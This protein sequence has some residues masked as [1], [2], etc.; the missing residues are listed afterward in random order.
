MVSWGALY[1]VHMS[2]HIISCVFICGL[3]PLKDY[4]VQASIGSGEWSV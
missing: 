2:R 4:K 1:E 3:H